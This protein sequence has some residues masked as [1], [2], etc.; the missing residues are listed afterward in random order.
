MSITNYD[1]I[2]DEIVFNSDGLVPG[3]AQQHDSG[4]VLMMAWMNRDAIEET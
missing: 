2:M 1:R 4:E 3:I